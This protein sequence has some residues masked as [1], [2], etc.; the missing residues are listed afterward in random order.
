MAFTFATC[1]CFRQW[2]G[3]LF[4][5]DV[6]P[7]SGFFRREDGWTFASCSLLFSAVFS[8]IWLTLA[9]L[10]P[11]R[12]QPTTVSIASLFT[13]STFLYFRSSFFIWMDGRL[14]WILRSFASFLIT[15]QFEQYARVV[16]LQVVFKLITSPASGMHISRSVWTDSWSEAI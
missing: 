3:S 7:S 11:F 13:H 14:L 5:G 12:L 1:S 8:A 16:S 15:K 10:F 2:S 6:G 4:S 9:R